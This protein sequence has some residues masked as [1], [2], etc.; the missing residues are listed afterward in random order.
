MAVSARAGSVGPGT[1]GGIG[2]AVGGLKN[3]TVVLYQSGKP[4]ARLTADTLT[5][6]QSRRS[7]VGTGKVVVR[8]LAL[9]DSPAIRSDTMT[10]RYDT[11]TIQ[12]TGNVL[13]TREPGTRIPGRAFTADTKLSRFTLEGGAGPASIRY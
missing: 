13:V 10:W 7:V 1:G 8:S 12:G 3:G 11:G 6:S 5:A 2:G 9:P 4:A